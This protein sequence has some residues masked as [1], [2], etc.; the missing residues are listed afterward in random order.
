MIT[1]IC[2]F[3]SSSFEI[4]AEQLYL[5]SWEEKQKKLDKLCFCSDSDENRTGTRNEDMLELVFYL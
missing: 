4:K 3:A 2:L 1:V 5:Y